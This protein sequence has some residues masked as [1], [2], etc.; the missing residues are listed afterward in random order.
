MFHRITSVN[1]VEDMRIIVHFVDNT[2]K[3]YDVK[4]LMKQ[5]S[6]FKVLL[7]PAVFKQVR[8]DVGGYGVSWNDELDISCNELWER[9]QLL[10]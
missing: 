7:V 9:G 5:S 3:C 6:S 2:S 1:P 8:V 4:P 10:L